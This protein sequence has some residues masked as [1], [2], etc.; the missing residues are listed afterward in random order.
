MSAPHPPPPGPAGYPTAPQPPPS[1]GLSIGALVTGIL[2][3][4][5]LI[6]CGLGGLVGLVAIVLGV[7]GV[8]KAAELGG[9]GR[10]ASITGIVT[11]ALSVVLAIVFLVV[12]AMFGAFWF[13]E[14]GPILEQI[15]QDIER[16]QQ[17]ILEDLQDESP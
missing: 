2:S 4:P 3:L 14:G 5:L 8:R 1:N 7:L 15:E 13:E 17:E 11:G 6:A 16:Q 12:L 9:L 10:G